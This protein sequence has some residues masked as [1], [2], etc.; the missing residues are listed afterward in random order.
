MN[1]GKLYQTELHQGHRPD[2]HP[3]GR[4]VRCIKDIGN[5]YVLVKCD[6][7]KEINTWVCHKKNLREIKNEK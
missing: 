3:N 1:V 4:I 7:I 6:S 5:E 2:L